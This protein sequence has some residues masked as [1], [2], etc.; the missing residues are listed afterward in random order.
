M[1]ES[2]CPGAAVLCPCSAQRM[3]PTVSQSLHCSPTLTVFATGLA[4]TMSATS[5]SYRAVQPRRSRYR[6][7]EDSPIPVQ[8]TGCTQSWSARPGPRLDHSRHPLALACANSCPQR[9]WTW[10]VNGF[11]FGGADSSTFA[12]LAEPDPMVPVPFR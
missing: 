7:D 1:Q 8:P 6:Q 11:E 10:R 12:L 2:A 5:G 4:E 9:R 3:L